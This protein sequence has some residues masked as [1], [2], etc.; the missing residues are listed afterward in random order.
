M[1]KPLGGIC[2]IDLKET[3]YRLIRRTLCFQFYN[4]FT[5]YLSSHQFG[6]ATKG[7]CE[8]TIHGM[9]SSAP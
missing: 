3:L 7:G 1:T 4:T 9:A 6:V 8:T 5:T 2:P